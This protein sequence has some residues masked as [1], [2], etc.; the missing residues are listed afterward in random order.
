MKSKIFSLI[1]TTFIVSNSYSNN[2]QVANATIS[3]N[4]IVFNLSWDNSWKDATNWDAAWVFVKYRFPNDDWH[5][6][7]L[8]TS[9]HNLPAGST[10]Y[11]PADGKGI[12][13]YRTTTG[14]G[15][16]NFQSIMLSWN[17]A[18]NGL[19]STQNLQVK[20]MAIE[21]A[22]VPLGSYYL[23]DGAALGRFRLASVDNPA[24]ISTTGAIVKCS[25]TSF[26]DAQLLGNGILVD[27][28]GGIDSDGTT[29]IDNT[30]FPTGYKAFYCMKYKIS[31]GQYA[32]F[33]NT[34]DATQVQTRYYATTG[35]RYTI[36]GTWPNYSAGAPD[37][38]CNYLSWMDGC[39]YSD[40]AGLR[41]LTELEF[42]KA[43]RGTSAFLAGE[44]AWGTANI[45]AGSYT[46]TGNGT[47]NELIS[48]PGVNTGNALY[49]S[50]YGS[51]QGPFRCGIFAASA[52]NKNRQETGSTIYGIMEMS[53]NLYERCVTLGNQT[54]RPF[55]GIN[56]NGELS[57]GGYADVS[58][59]PGYSYGIVQGAT[60]SGFRGGSWAN[61]STT[62]QV[63]DRQEAAIAVASRSN[64]YG[65][66]C[67]RSAP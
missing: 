51:N 4:F 26:D 65:F 11:M 20:V 36:A 29:S 1:L 35:D 21:M 38:A 59:W 40:W 10:A 50:T 43:C 27:G 18:A 31:Q 44:Y 53:G 24:Q 45:F 30:D 62:L 64:G 52:V 39:A 34:I 48:N 23:G 14:I 22:F 17:I 54:G 37:R 7:E 25:S 46:L 15:S 61:A 58:L 19:T 47:S 28:D 60:G 42:E 3:G 49:I 67:V 63:S 5:H 32:D 66:R 56:G 9:G 2:I 12:F 6:V 57:P 16:N 55:T 41:P 33:L 13:I 8:N